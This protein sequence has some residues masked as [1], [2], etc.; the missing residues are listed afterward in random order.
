MNIRPAKAR[1]F[2]LMETVAAMA[3]L[4]TVVILIAQVG[5]WSLHERTRNSARHEALEY[6][7]NILES[8]R[9][10]PFD[11]LNSEWGARQKLADSLPVSYRQGKLAIDVKPEPGLPNTKRVTVQIDCVPGGKI[12]EPPIRLTALI[13]ARQVPFKGGKP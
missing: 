6:A 2:T 4:S 11:S 1:G 8:A 3:L 5:I 7:A 13:S 12:P 9:A 10:L